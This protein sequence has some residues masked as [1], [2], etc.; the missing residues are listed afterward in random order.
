VEGRGH[1]ARRRAPALPGLLGGY[2]RTV[3]TL[4]VR[5]STSRYVATF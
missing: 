3:V 5:T 4:Q 2:S 1:F